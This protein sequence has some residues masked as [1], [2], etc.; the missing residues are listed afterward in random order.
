MPIWSTANNQGGGGG[1]SDSSSQPDH[2]ANVESETKQIST[3]E[4]HVRVKSDFGSSKVVMPYSTE[5]SDGHFVDLFRD[6]GSFEQLITSHDALVGEIRETEKTTE[7]HLHLVGSHRDASPNPYFPVAS[8]NVKF[9]AVDVLGVTHSVMRIDETGE[10]FEG[11]LLDQ[12]LIPTS[13]FTWTV[14]G[15]FKHDGADFDLSSGIFTIGDPT[16]QGY[17]MS[18]IFKSSSKVKLW[19]GKD[20]SGSEMSLTF[21][22]LASTLLD[23]DWHTIAITNTI[24]GLNGLEIY[25]DDMSTP[26]ESST[27]NGGYGVEI[28][29]AGFSVGH[30]RHTDASNAPVSG[31]YS[32]WQVYQ[33]TLTEADL[34][35]LKDN[36]VI[37]I[38]DL[39]ELGMHE[40]LRAVYDGDLNKWDLLN[41]D[42]LD[43]RPRVKAVSNVSQPIPTYEGGHVVTFEVSKTLVGIGLSSGAIEFN[44]SGIYSLHAMFNMNLKDAAASGDIEAW[45]EKYNEGS[46]SWGIVEDSGRH[47]EFI[48]ATLATEGGTTQDIT[49]KTDGTF[50]FFDNGLE[51]KKGDKLRILV[52]CTVTGV[53]LSAK[54]L[55]NGTKAPSAILSIA[56]V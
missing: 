39:S 24:N 14:F 6:K 19:F 44:E 2:Y 21:N 12:E 35:K 36:A 18:L 28:R 52:R 5:V 15:R 17:A 40:S 27:I 9:E 48:T 33:E 37:E 31:F 26:I 16:H 23:G 46:S 13:M 50:D 25:V 42:N 53:E 20:D 30:A 3:S 51:A 56:K 29:G 32:N 43:S 54:T 11:V 10:E 4:Q 38:S 55:E 47:K 1:G 41:F 45:I 22:F 34:N 7:A 8:D 49:F